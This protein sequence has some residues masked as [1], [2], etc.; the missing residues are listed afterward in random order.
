[1]EELYRQADRSSTL[2]DN[3]CS[4]TQIVMIISKLVESKKPEGKKPFEPKEGKNRS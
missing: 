3:I 4:A 1:M 2:E